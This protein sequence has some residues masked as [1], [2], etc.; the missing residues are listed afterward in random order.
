MTS[1]KRAPTLPDIPSFDESGLPGFE[2]LAWI[3]AYVPAK[4]PKA[5]VAK[6]NSMITTILNDPATASFL[7]STGATPFP[8]T[9][10]QLSTFAETD[11]K[12]WATI[13]EAAKMEK[14]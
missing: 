9:P 7:S 1:T 6:L 11:T 12:R 14:Q 5:N 8:T 4:T 2:L 13:V 10:E 3:A